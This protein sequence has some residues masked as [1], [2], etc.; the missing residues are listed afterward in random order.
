M[1]TVS[2]GF[3]RSSKSTRN[4]GEHSKSKA[5]QGS[6]NNDAFTNRSSDHLSDMWPR[7]GTHPPSPPV[8]QRARY[9]YSQNNTACGGHNYVFPS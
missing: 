7:H 4:S 9:G 1:A 6:S 3:G 5:L 8:R 2:T